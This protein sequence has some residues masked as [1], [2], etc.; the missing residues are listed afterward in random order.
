MLYNVYNKRMIKQKSDYGTVKNAIEKMLGDTVSVYVDLGR[1]KHTSYKGVVSACY[2]AL[3]TVSP[4]D[5]FSGQ[6]SLRTGKYKK[7]RLKAHS[8]NR[9]F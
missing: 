4:S 8:F 9:P 1:N 7:G 3:F 5:T 2:P 6:T